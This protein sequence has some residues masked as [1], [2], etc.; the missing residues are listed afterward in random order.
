MSEDAVDHV[1]HLAGRGALPKGVEGGLLRVPA[2]GAAGCG[3]QRLARVAMS[4]RGPGCREVV[5]RDLAEEDL[6]TYVAEV[7]IDGETLP[8]AEG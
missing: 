3:R 1:P 6:A 4:R 2:V 8:G 5:R 7:G